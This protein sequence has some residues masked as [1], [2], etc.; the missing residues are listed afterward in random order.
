MANVNYAIGAVAVVDKWVEYASRANQ[1]LCCSNPK[2]V[3]LVEHVVEGDDNVSFKDLGC[4]TTVD[5]TINGKVEKRYRFG[6]TDTI[7]LGTR[8]VVCPTTNKLEVDS[9]SIVCGACM[10]V[11]AHIGRGGLCR[12][13]LAE[14]PGDVDV[15]TLPRADPHGPRITALEQHNTNSY[16]EA[17]ALEKIR[18]ETL[19]NANANPNRGGAAVQRALLED[20]KAELT[21]ATKTATVAKKAHSKAKTH[22]AQME[23]GYDRNAEPQEDL[24]LGDEDDAAA[25]AFYL[26]NGKHVGLLREHYPL[27][28]LYWY[29]NPPTDEAIAQGKSSVDS[30]RSTWDKTAA[31]AVAAA[32]SVTEAETMLAELG[33][34]YDDGAAV[35]ADPNAANPDAA[36]NKRGFPKKGGKKYKGKTYEEM[37]DE[38]KRVFDERN[39]L[40]KEKRK[41]KAT[42]DRMRID[43]YPRV[44]K[45]AAKY[46]KA[47]EEKKIANQA[48]VFQ[49]RVQ[50]DWLTTL[51]GKPNG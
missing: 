15:A 9:A 51:R 7:H 26:D 6:S 50:V 30:T 42:E 36:A 20:R 35:V 4:E 19:S 41:K 27:C 11:G 8:S 44:Y 18:E 28:A 37:D 5:V 25:A 23:Q 22:L 48:R 46:E 38:E 14:A 3:H 43:Q 47:V 33:Q 29:G 13:S 2:C 10:A 32:L 40:A 31:T 45:R 17:D 24:D 39:A 34:D 1:N 16:N 21:S 49:D 12:A